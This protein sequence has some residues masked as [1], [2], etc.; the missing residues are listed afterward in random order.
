MRAALEVMH[1]RVLQYLTLSDCGV[2]CTGLRESLSSLCM[3][4]VAGL[5]SCLLQLVL[6]EFFILTFTI[7]LATV[8]SYLS[9]RT[10]LSTES[11]REGSFPAR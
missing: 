11:G 6:V 8:I 5:A 3:R 9:A 4:G 7:K 10:Q 1:L 2:P